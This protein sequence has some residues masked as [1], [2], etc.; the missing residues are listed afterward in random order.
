[1]A[2][3]Y[4]AVLG[5]PKDAS[6]DDIKKAYKKLAKQWHPDINKSPDAAEKFK[7]INEAAAALG[8]PKKREQYDRF[9]TAEA[10]GGFNYQDFAG[11]GTNF[12]DV[13][14]SLFS[15]FGFGGTRGGPRRGRDAAY[16]V[17]V[18]L[19]EA[20]KGVTKKIG[21]EKLS[22]CDECDGKGGTGVT[23]C[24]NCRGSG[25]VQ[26]TQRTPF[27]YFAT[28]T[29]CKDC[30][31][32]GERIEHPCKV[33]KGAGRLM[34][35]KTLDVRIPAG[36]D[37]GTRLRVPGQGEAG[38]R[39]ASAGDLYVIIHVEEH[40]LFSRDGN[41][42]QLKA[43][44][45]FAAACLGGELEVPTLEG[46]TTIKIPAGTQTGTTFRLA[47]KGIP[48]V[49]GRGT[50]AELVTVQVEVPKK[51][52]AKQKEL[53]QEFEGLSGKKKGWLW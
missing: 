5:V 43:P 13:F 41:D 44:I 26:R 51:L 49:H 12:D 34:Q 11:F 32:S 29:T 38:E 40:E 8:D 35:E 50:G 3:D 31:G 19:E 15:G 27:G 24:D 7:E 52:T 16:D 6:H 17:D 23:T 33:C 4:Y 42:I 48:D 22:A 1:M 47:G 53:L 21:V 30:N 18:K 37:D 36:V 45:S 2:K 10:G 28:T 14:E 9:G 39:G 20:A 46:K 25:Q